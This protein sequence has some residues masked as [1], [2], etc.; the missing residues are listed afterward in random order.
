MASIDRRSTNQCPAR[1][2]KTAPTPRI[3]LLVLG[4]LCATT[5]PGQV[6]KPKVVRTGAKAP[7]VI[8]PM[9]ALR[10]QAVYN[11]AGT[12]DWSVV[13]KDAVWVSSSRVNR[14]SQ[15][16]PA[17]GQVGL[18]AHV[19]LP[20]SG[21]AH[22]WGSVW[23]PSCGSH[24]LVRID[25]KTGKATAS[26]AADPA[27]S[28][29]GIT[30]G[31][32]SV[33]LVTKPSRLVRI[34]PK[35]NTVIKSLDLP[36]GS[37][38]PAFGGGFVWVSSSAAN[39]VLKVDPETNQIAATISVGPGPRFLTVGDGSVWTLNQGD[40]TISRVDMT[41]GKVIATVPC[42]IPGYGGEISYGN[43]YVWATMFDFPIT[44]VDPKSNQP[45]RQWTGA[46]GDGLRFGLGSVWLSNG[47]EGTVW[48]I[49]PEQR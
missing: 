45:V 6:P 38:N 8:R 27:N 2:E 20:C 39:A 22:G 47:K 18:I 12:P 4:V 11:L 5:T 37:E 23:V 26:I 17:T 36:A 16:V 35:T 33:W 14:V 29:G 30:I 10:P 34:D 43:G 1:E 44:Q 13:T 31:D 3:A 28:E 21:L 49:A 46:G 48:Q 42:G 41:T 25:E 32:G 15:L 40:G 19:Q 7:G 9:S 24:E